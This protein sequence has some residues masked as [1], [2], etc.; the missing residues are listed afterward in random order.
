MVGPTQHVRSDLCC[1][2][3]EPQRRSGRKH[4]GSG[5]VGEYLKMLSPGV[6]FGRSRDGRGV[7]GEN[8]RQDQAAQGLWAADV[9][10]DGGAGHTQGPRNIA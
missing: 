10:V 1:R 3:V 2:F 8:G 6:P 7:G 5:L 4:P 9:V